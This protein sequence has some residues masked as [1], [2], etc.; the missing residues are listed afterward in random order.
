LAREE[1]A[2]LAMPLSFLFQVDLAE[3]PD[4]VERDALPG[5]GLLAFFASTTT[6]TPD[7]RFAKRVASTVLF[8]PDT[9]N[10][11]ATSQP[12][13]PDPW[14]SRPLTLRAERRL[15]A[16]LPWEEKQALR[17]RTD[18]AVMHRFENEVCRRRDALFPRPSDESAGPIPP[19]GEVALARLMEHD[20][21]DFFVGDASWLTFCLPRADLAMQRFENA[22]A[23]VY[24]G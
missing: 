2:D 7:P 8:V 17:A 11:V 12:P 16:E 23:S 1:E 5:S 22:R 10:L 13:T 21:L 9:G 14:P 24:V 4:C 19:S 6:D 20:E 15:Y 3:L 18:P